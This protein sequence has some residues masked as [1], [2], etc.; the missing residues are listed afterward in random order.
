MILGDWGMLEACR[1]NIPDSQQSGTWDVTHLWCDE[2]E[3]S[4]ESH[5]VVG[6]AV[7]PLPSGRIANIDSV[8][9]V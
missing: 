7:I 2:L 8:L 1:G 4:I 5:S 3:P 6:I 9:P